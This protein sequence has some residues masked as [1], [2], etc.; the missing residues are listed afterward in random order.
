MGPESG[1]C[2]DIMK[3]MRRYLQNRGYNNLEEFCIGLTDEPDKY[4]S[5][6]EGICFIFM[7]PSHSKID[8]ALELNKIVIEALEK[9]LQSNPTKSK[10]TY[11]IFE[12]VSEELTGYLENKRKNMPKK[13]NY[14]G[15]GYVDKG[16]FDVMRREVLSACNEFKFNDGFSGQQIPDGGQM[17]QCGSPTC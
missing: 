17:N 5:E 6:P 12:D 11:I 14:M 2:C 13:F 16:E 7:H 8:S 10:N 1:D 4:I 15:E 9:W 3:D